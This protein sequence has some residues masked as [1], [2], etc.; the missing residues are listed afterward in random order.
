MKTRTGFISNSSSTSFVVAIP[1]HVSKEE[2]PLIEIFEKIVDKLKAQDS[3][4]G[5][6]FVLVN[7]MIKEYDDKISELVGEREHYQ[8]FYNQVSEFMRNKASQAAVQLFLDIV[9]KSKAFN[10]LKHGATPKK[11]LS[12][13]QS[14]TQKMIQDINEKIKGL[15]EEKQQVIERG[16]DAKY[17]MSF[18]LDHWASDIEQVLEIMIEKD[19]VKLVKKEST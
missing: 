15:S 12:E 6:G 10:Y 5:Y 2:E 17:I 8:N 19:I 3:D 1:A 4:F 16:R 9:E 18:T 7:D 13:L 11:H 14:D